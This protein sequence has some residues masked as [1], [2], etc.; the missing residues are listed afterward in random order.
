[1]IPTT[2]RYAPNYPQTPARQTAPA[3]QRPAAQRQGF[4]DGLYEYFFRIATQYIAEREA[5]RLKMVKPNDAEA[6]GD[7]IDKLKTIRASAERIARIL[8]KKGWLTRTLEQKEARI[9]HSTTRPHDFSPDFY[10]RAFRASIEERKAEGK[11]TDTPVGEEHNLKRQ[12]WVDLAARINRFFDGV[13]TFDISAHLAKQPALIDKSSD[14]VNTFEIPIL[15][16]KQ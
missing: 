7:Q 3:A 11:I 4:T 12:R 2:T 14:E 15:L 6:I 10:L 1:M 9:Q 13:N 5:E 8:G 16:A